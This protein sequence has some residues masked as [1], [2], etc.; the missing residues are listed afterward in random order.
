MIGQ[1]MNQLPATGNLG[2][3]FSCFT[4]S[5]LLS[6]CAIESFSASVAFSMPNDERFKDFDFDKYKRA[7]RFWDKIEMLCGAIQLEIDR[8]QGMFQ[9]I[10]EMQRWRNLVTHAS[11]YEINPTSIENTVDAPTKLHEP[12]RSKEYTRMTDVGNAKV[13]YTTA[14]EYIELIKIRSDLDPRASVSYTIG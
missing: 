10:G 14:F 2:R 1:K 12:F 7:S 13:F 6:F 11:P 9:K 4:G 5:M 3:G 8:S